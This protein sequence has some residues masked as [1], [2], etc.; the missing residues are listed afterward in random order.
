MNITITYITNTIN[1]AHL[2]G[3]KTVCIHD[4]NIITV[5]KY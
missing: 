3:F 5:I 1:Q 2:N 4:N